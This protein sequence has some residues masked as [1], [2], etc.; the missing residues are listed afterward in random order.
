MLHVY[1]CIYTILSLN[2]C[3]MY[4]SVSTPFYSSLYVT[5][6]SVYLHHFI[7]HSVLYVLQCI[8]T[9]TFSLCVTCRSVYLHHFVLHSVLY[10]HQCIYIIIH[11]SFY[12]PLCVTCTSE[13]LLRSIL[14]SVLPVDQCIYIILCFTLRYT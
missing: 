11:T 6:R 4:I 8:Y 13:Y 2:L 1:Q 14:H 9:I 7:L 5:C 12:L 3:Y 10:V